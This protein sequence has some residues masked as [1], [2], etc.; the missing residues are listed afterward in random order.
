[1]PMQE[2]QM[3]MKCKLCRTTLL[4]WDSDD[5]DDAQA[6]TPLEAVESELD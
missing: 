3:Q 2:Q 6:V 1:M 5:A 4:G